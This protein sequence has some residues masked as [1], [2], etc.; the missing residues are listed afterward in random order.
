MY[1]NEVFGYFYFE[2]ALKEMMQFFSPVILF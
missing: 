2:V 1:L